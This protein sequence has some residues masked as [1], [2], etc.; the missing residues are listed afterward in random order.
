[1]SILLRKTT[2]TANLHSNMFTKPSE[3]CNTTVLSEIN[4]HMVF[5]ISN[6]SWHT[7]VAF[8]SFFLGNSAIELALQV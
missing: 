2:L 7:I 5:C 3:I 4:L 8:C 1:M 6:L